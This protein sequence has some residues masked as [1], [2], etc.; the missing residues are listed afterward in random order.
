[1]RDSRTLPTCDR[2]DFSA[3][4]HFLIC[5]YLTEMK[6][7]CNDYSCD[8]SSA[9]HLFSTAVAGRCRLILKTNDMQIKES[10][11]CAVIHDFIEIIWVANIINYYNN[12]RQFFFIL[13]EF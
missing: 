13:I 10:E 2:L 4:L 8:S 5:Y 7:S 1:M 9:N 12:D 3:R 11:F 6:R